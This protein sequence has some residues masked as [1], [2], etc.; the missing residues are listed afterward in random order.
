MILWFQQVCKKRLVEFFKEE[1]EHLCCQHYV[2]SQ[3]VTKKI[4]ETF[5]ISVPQKPNL[6]LIKVI[7]PNSAAG[8]SKR[9]KWY[10]KQ[11]CPNNSYLI[12]QFDMAANWFSSD[13]RWTLSNHSHPPNHFW[14]K[15]QKMWL[16]HC[17]KTHHKMSQLTFFHLSSNIWIFAPIRIWITPHKRDHFKPF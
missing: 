13:I 17:M 7:Y 9:S 16:T 1:K 8:C 12:F 4:K 15:T 5:Q 14:D 2:I 3:E 11:S 10:H 6:M